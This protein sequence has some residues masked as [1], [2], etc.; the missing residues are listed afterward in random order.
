M[1][2]SV[3]PHRRQPT[4][5]PRPWDSPGK[6]TGVGCHF[7][8]ASMV[9]APPLTLPLQGPCPHGEDTGFPLF[10][11]HSLCSRTFTLQLHVSWPRWL[12]HS[13]FHQAPR[14]PHLRLLFPPLAQKDSKKPQSWKRPSAAGPATAVWE[15]SLF[16]RAGRQGAELCGPV[17]GP[18]SGERTQD[19]GCD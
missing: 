6:N 8:A 15:L 12:T 14:A 1:S 5:L 2:D 13:S 10:S 18:K 11:S 17:R 7:H 3:R 16:G 19:S 4:R 9:V